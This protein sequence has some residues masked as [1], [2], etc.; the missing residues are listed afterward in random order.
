MCCSR[1]GSSADT[2]HVSVSAAT[3]FG[4]RHGL[5]TLSQ[6]ISYDE[7]ADTLQVSMA[8]YGLIPIVLQIYETALVED[9]PS[10]AH[11]GLLL[12]TSRNFMSKKVAG[13]LSLLP[14]FLPRLSNKSSPGCRTIS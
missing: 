5:E 2:V 3:Y 8:Y 12:D 7:L 9:K 10:F 6:M 11:R 13:S 4:A 14:I 1:Q